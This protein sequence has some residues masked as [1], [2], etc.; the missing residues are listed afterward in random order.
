[1]GTV[2]YSPLAEGLSSVGGYYNSSSS[3]VVDAYCQKN[4]V[5]VVSP[6]VSSEDQNGYSQSYFPEKQAFQDYDGDDVAGKIGEGNVKADST[7]YTI[8]TEFNGSTYL[9]DMA[10]Y[11]Y[12]SDV[13]GYED[14]FQN[15]YTY[16]I[17]FM[18]DEESNVFLINT[19]NNGNGNL[20][21]YD[22][23]D[24]EYGKYHFVAESPNS[25]SDVLLEA[26]KDIISRTY[27]FVAPVVPVTRT[28]SGDRV[29][30]AFFQP[31]EGNFW[32]GNVAKFGL[33]SNNEIIDSAGNS[34]TWPNGALKEDATPYWAT[35]DWADS[36]KPNYI[37]NSQRNIYTYM[38]F[39]LELTSSSNEFST[40]NA[41]LTT[42]ILGNPT[43]TAGEIIN[44]I[45]GMDVFDEDDDSYTSENRE[46]ITGDLIHGE[47]LL[48]K[49]DSS[50][51][52]M[53]FGANDG[54]LH[55]VSDSDGSEMWAFIPP[56]QLHRLK[57]IVEGIG[58]QFFVDSSPK[59]YKKDVDWDGV[60]E[61]GDG[62][63]VILICGERK[64]GTSYFALDVTIPAEPKFLWRINQKDDAAAG[65]APPA[66]GPN[67]VIPE[68][69][70]SWAEPRFGR[71]KT[72]ADDTT[73]TD[74]FFIGGGYS[75]D[76][77]L[78]K[79]VFAINPL[80]GQD[81]PVAVVKAFKNDGVDITDM[82]YS[83]PSAIYLVD[84]DSNGF[85]DKVYVGDL[86]SQ[87]WRFGR[88]TDSEGD[89]LVFPDS[90]E[91]INNWEAQVIFLSDST[92]TRKFFY[93]PSV[94]LEKGYDLVLMGTGNREDA[95]NPTCSERI[96]AVKDTHGFA[97]LQEPDLVDV[98]D[99]TAT[100]PDLKNE[101]GDVDANGQVDQGWYIQLAAGEKVLEEGTVFYKVF[102]VTTFT[103]NDDPCV[104]GGVAKLYA[105]QYQTGAA[106][107]TFGGADLARSTSI[108]GGI[109]SKPVIVITQTG[110]KLL[111]SVGSA[112]PD[113]TSQST[114]AGIIAKEPLFPSRNFFYKWWRET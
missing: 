93:P 12:V 3:H 50:T 17:G 49:Y 7:T 23:S 78:G 109:P 99:P 86:G 77:S 38:G 27:T 4:F 10:H 11:L 71:V 82:N 57:D 101:T 21:L 84:A 26:I 8:P 48:V 103:P 91:D 107:L 34:A 30:L 33:S 63:K 67:V 2:T 19:S 20:N 80:T 96:Y 88:F 94:T 112:N 24:P 5:I 75:S 89:P 31:L 47:P 42:A 39:S 18:G 79:A 108:G 44:Y 104:P 37:D 52:V 32:K 110:A 6:G 55:A 113:A 69:G 25:L 28:T 114:G 40:G 76:N 97:T 74:V 95:C 36:A 15:V 72:S 100:P 41:S 29:Y 62:D 83:I 64:G 87:M 35:I 51:A 22:T 46:V 1:M 58:H 73:G 105:L 43:H 13:V 81:P 66:A 68:L 90:D 56:D 59:V 60:I 61:P 53:Y 92:H 45:R 70:E 98:T 85:V 16:T 14:G 65:T 9:D 111:A 106:V 102:Y 54:M